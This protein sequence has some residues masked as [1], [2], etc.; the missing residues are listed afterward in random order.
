MTYLGGEEGVIDAACR[1]RSLL[2][3]HQHKLVQGLQELVTLAEGGVSAA[4]L[5]KQA[6]PNRLALYQ[7]L[8]AVL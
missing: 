2:F 5:L 6:H 8:V 3:C 7:T 4:E 1:D